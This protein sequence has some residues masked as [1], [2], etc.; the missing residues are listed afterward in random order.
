[1]GTK[2]SDVMDQIDRELAADPQMRQRIETLLNEI[3]IEQGIIALREER[4]MSQAQVAK[5]LGVSQPAIAKIEGGRARNIELRTLAKMAAALGGRIK[6]EIVKDPGWKAAGPA[7]A[8]KRKLA[9]T[10]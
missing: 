3:N 8:S 6:L 2:R 5:L 4:G 7:K 1:M 10:A 9:K